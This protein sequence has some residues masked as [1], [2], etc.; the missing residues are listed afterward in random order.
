MNE[1]LLFEFPLSPV[2]KHD[3]DNHSI[4]MPQE[5]GVFS[6]TKRSDVT[7]LVSLLE[8]LSDKRQ[9]RCNYCLQKLQLKSGEFRE[10]AGFI[11]NLSRYTK[12][13]YMS[14]DRLTYWYP[15]DR[16]FTV[17]NASCRCC[18]MCLGEFQSRQ[19][20]CWDGEAQLWSLIKNCEL[21]IH[22]AL[23]S[24]SLRGP[25]LLYAPSFILVLLLFVFGHLLPRFLAVT[26]VL[27]PKPLKSDGVSGAEWAGMVIPLAFFL[28]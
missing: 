15:G 1:H 2:C 28:Y 25:R 23:V 3:L 14:L 20:G 8:V 10:P 19:A 12:L 4:R 9:L 27:S 5:T 13:F 18:F 16:S 11:W 7:L 24:G 17:I 6:W 22:H 21:Y 26:K